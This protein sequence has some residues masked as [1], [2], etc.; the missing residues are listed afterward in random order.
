MR[1]EQKT[2]AELIRELQAT[3][4]RAARLD[5]M[6]ERYKQIQVQLQESNVLHDKTLASLN[7][8]VFVV[9]PHTRAIIEWNT[10]AEEMFGYT[11]AEMLGQDTRMLHATDEMFG[12]FGR[13]AL[14]AYE[15]V[16]YFATE[17]W[18]RRKSGQVFPTEHF[19][20]PIYDADG[21]IEI[22][23]S[24]VRDITE[25]RRVEEA[26]RESQERLALAISGTRAG[27]WDWLVQTSQVVFNERWAE[28]VGYTL[29]ELAPVSIE[30]WE[31][32]AH[33]DDLA[34]SNQLLQKHFAGES[35]Y[36][37]CEARMRHKNG[38]WVWVLDRGQVVEW[39]AAHR[40]VRMT[41]THLDITG[42]K[43][44]EQA[45]QE[46]RDRAQRY[47][48]VA[49][50]MIVALDEEARVR[51]I[52]KKGCA[53]LGYTEDQI[54]GRNWFELC[55]PARLHLQIREII[56]QV[57]IKQF[58]FLSYCEYPIV[59]ASGGERILGV[60]ST[61]L[62]DASG[63]RTGI[64][65]SGEDVTERRQISEEL[66][67]HSED[68]IVLNEIASR[69]NQPL[70]STEVAVH[71]LEQ[72][73]KSLHVKAGV[74]WTLNDSG[75]WAFGGQVSAIPEIR[76]GWERIDPSVGILGRAVQLRDL[77]VVES[78]A[79]T[80]LN[81]PLFDRSDLYPCAAIPLQA[82]ENLRGILLLFGIVPR[83]QSSQ[84]RHL[85]RGIGYHLGMAIENIRLAERAAEIEILRELD[86]LRSELIANVSHELRTPLGLIK[87]CCSA[88]LSEDLG[89]SADIQAEFLTDIDE[90]TD[91]LS[92][93]VDNLLDLSRM[94]SG[95]LRLECRMTDLAAL[96]RRVANDLGGHLAQFH[97]T[98]DFLPE[99]FW[100]QV[101]AARIDQVLVNLISNAIKYSPQGGTLRVQGRHNEEQVIVSVSDEGIGIPAE[102]LERV[103]ER[104]YRVNDPR[105][106][107]ASGVGLGLAVC[108]GIIEAHGGRIWAESSVGR[109]ST[110]LFTLPLRGATSTDTDQAS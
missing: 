54:L 73:T 61:M 107:S 74:A 103:F 9:N 1:D 37:E 77:V 78:F 11:R 64:L 94:Q 87:T 49:G 86:R 81:Q 108:R 65:F 42:R 10:T 53:I 58:E 41:G 105:L 63:H 75:M 69:L 47:L 82:R 40:P 15:Q 91:R 22:V 46:Q 4:R 55:M 3:R 79:E 18:M 38:E 24:V 56:D 84:G 8:A 33:P 25:R 43:C 102:D 31:R 100:V 98:W 28:I 48:D 13:D 104:F 85:L 6:T 16:G 76:F 7:E 101:D 88:L 32:L 72:L 14:H 30:T 39:D 59:S 110:F 93:L 62:F 27:L 5:K 35:E 19:V 89:L 52:N 44:T 83:T 34:R 66:R 99:P 20:R 71:V 97:L 50:V 29:A 17:F 23:V 45:L 36:Y 67:R 21:R 92:K 2:K 57:R 96:A 106:P 70:R 51:L 80:G 60:R 95:H 90:Q 109:G 12:R 26:L 68:L